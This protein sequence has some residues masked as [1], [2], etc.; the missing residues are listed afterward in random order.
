MEEDNPL[1][2]KKPS[3]IK[4]KSPNYFDLSETQNSV[5]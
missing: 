4:M 1:I 2:L 3:T 5:S